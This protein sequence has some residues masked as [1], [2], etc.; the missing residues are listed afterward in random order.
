MRDDLPQDDASFGLPDGKTADE[1]LSEMRQRA[2]WCF[3]ADSSLTTLAQQDIKFCDVPGYQWDDY[4]KNE[5]RGRPCYEFNRTRKQIQQI[6]NEEKHNRPSIKIRA[7]KDATEDDADLRMGIVRNIESTS[8][9][10]LAYDLAYDFAVKGGKGAWRINTE[11][12]DDDAFDQEICIEPFHDPFL[13]TLDPSATTFERRDA[14]FGFVYTILPRSEFRKRYP[15]SE[16]VDFGTLR[17]SEGY[18]WNDW[19]GEDTVRI[20]EYWYKQPAEKEI[21]LMSDGSTVNAK[22]AEPLMPL[23]AQTGVTILRKRTVRYDE[24]Y[25]CIA[26]GSEILEKPRLWAGSNIPLIIVWGNLSRID[27][28]PYWCGEV[29]YM[30]DAQTTYNYERSTLVEVIAD[31]PKMPLMAAAEAIEGY[32]DD[33]ASLGVSR[34]PVLLYNHLADHPNGGMPQRVAPPTFPASL[35]QAADIS[36]ND[37]SATSNVYNAQLGAQSNETSGVAIHA[38]NAQGAL[39]NFNYMDNLAKAMRYTGEQLNE[40]I[41]KIYDT[42]REIRLMGIDGAAKIIKVNHAV[43]DPATGRYVMVNDLSKGKYDITVD[44]G[45]SYTTQRMETAEAMSNMAQVPGPF[46]P[47]MQ[48]A[49]LKSLDVPDIEDV[50]EAA[51][52]MLV[53]QGMLPPSEGDQPPQP[54]QPPQPNPL[55]MAAVQLKTAQAHKAQAEAMATQVKTQQ[56]IQFAPVEA[57]HSQ[58]TAAKEF[59]DAAHAHVK[60]A[61][62]MAEHMA[63]IPPLPGDPSLQQPPNRA[64]LPLQQPGQF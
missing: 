28:K 21:W 16:I 42:E 37:I 33:Y 60:T 44:I 5:R 15:N 64:V 11:W 3:D 36:A 12:S 62:E 7:V 40:L 52:M 63:K 25:S 39:S 9:A 43:Q 23:L 32:E 41:P 31:Q 26:S 48:Y 13:V 10:A 59:A 14:R 4:T 30:R 50:Q 53:K 29:R 35:A 8:N 20:A 58:A 2:Q 27:G 51:R 56:S 19:W 17:G 45:P 34:R 6:T 38:R 57:Q 61:R 1:F 54:Q 22:E 47:L 18:D 55:A 24:V 49:Y 46:Q